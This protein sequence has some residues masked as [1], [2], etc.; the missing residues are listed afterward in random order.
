MDYTQGYGIKARRP[1]TPMRG[2]YSPLEV[3][4][5]HFKIKKFDPNAQTNIALSNQARLDFAAQHLPPLIV[6]G[7][8]LHYRQMHKG[9]DGLWQVAYTSSKAQ[10]PWSNF[11][12]GNCF[13]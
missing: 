3:M 11:R 1:Y 7:N 2:L 6:E 12:R 10:H 8:V 9:E 5:T 4:T 13:S